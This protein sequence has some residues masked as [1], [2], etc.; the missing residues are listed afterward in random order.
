MFTMFSTLGIREHNICFRL[1]LK[2]KLGFAGICEVIDKLIFI[3]SVT[4]VITAPLEGIFQSGPK[5]RIDRIKH[6]KDNLL[7]ALTTKQQERTY[8]AGLQKKS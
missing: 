7:T 8:L 5:Q 4:P 3:L 2:T 1:A 6:L